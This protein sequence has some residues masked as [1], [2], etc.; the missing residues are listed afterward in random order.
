MM[1]CAPKRKLAKIQVY[2]D[3]RQPLL[4]NDS[5]L[6][7]GLLCYVNRRS[8]YGNWRTLLRQ[9]ANLQC[10]SA[11]LGAGQAIDHVRPPEAFGGI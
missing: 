4:L 3:F 9:L 8:S 11:E 6:V 2:I 7:A 10:Q 5:S 1:I